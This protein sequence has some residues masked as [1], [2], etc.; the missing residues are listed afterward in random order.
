MCICLIYVALGV[1]KYNVHKNK[2]TF[3]KT[4]ILL[5]IKHQL[6]MSKQHKCLPLQALSREFPVQ[7]QWGC[8]TPARAPDFHWHLHPCY[9]PGINHALKNIAIK[10]RLS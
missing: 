5:K 7:V 4:A 2:I 10:E 9:Q 3:F 6:V 1:G 8:T